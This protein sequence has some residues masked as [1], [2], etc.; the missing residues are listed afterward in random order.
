[1]YLA[2]V[3]F[4]L[5]PSLSNVDKKQ[6]A[7]HPQN[8]ERIMQ[9]GLRRPRSET[10]YQ[11]QKLVLWSFAYY[12]VLC[13]SSRSY[14]ILVLICASSDSYSIFHHPCLQAIIRS[15][16]SDCGDVILCEDISNESRKSCFLMRLMSLTSIINI[17]LLMSFFES[18]QSHLCSDPRQEQAWRYDAGT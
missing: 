16:F 17:M 2:P 6:A 15:S 7:K 8:S 1:M 11:I 18:S 13:T 5:R 3:C 4:S 12:G 9:T 14:D 10:G